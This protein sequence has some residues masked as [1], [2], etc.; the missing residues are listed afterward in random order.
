MKPLGSLCLCLLLALCAG[1]ATTTTTSSA[2]S[3]EVLVQEEPL[4]AAPMLDTAEAPTTYLEQ[5]MEVI[6]P[7][8]IPTELN[9]V[10][11]LTDGLGERVLVQNTTYH[12]TPSN[13]L[14]VVTSFKNITKKDV[15]LK[16]RTQFFDGDRVHQEGPRAWTMVF[17][18]PQG[19]DTYK[20]HSYDKDALYYYVEVVE[21]D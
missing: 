6:V 3:E 7:P 17:L 21:M 9:S 8:P 19:I 14:E 5:D 2:D 12:R 13:T 11:F 10:A 16:V 1:C 15:R 18:P 4:E 20:S